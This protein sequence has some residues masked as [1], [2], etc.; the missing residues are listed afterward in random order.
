[1]LH[2]PNFFSKSWFL[3]DVSPSYEMMTHFSKTIDSWDGDTSLGN[4]LLEKIFGK[5][6]IFLGGMLG[7]VGGIYSTFKVG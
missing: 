5:C 3:S 2:F 1:M 4:Q 7:R 6:S